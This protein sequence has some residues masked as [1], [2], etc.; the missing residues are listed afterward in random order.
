MRKA[1]ETV[2]KTGVFIAFLVFIATLA[3]PGFVFGWGVALVFWFSV[4]FFGQLKALRR[5]GW[6]RS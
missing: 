5:Q 1:L 4:G 2:G 3:I 6:L